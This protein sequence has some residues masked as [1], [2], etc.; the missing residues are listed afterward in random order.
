LE[1]LNT[2][3]KTVGIFLDLSKAYDVINHKILFTNL[4]DYGI[5][6][7]VNKWLQSYLTG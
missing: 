1:A 7:V 4:E 6:G 3:T 5:R 2:K